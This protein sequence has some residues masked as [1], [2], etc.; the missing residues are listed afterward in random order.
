MGL[1]IIPYGDKSL[2]YPDID[3]SKIKMYNYE[4]TT[5]DY[6]T[7]LNITI[8]KKKSLKIDFHE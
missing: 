4:E 7:C 1:K 8:K 6:D 3:E 5:D 2:L